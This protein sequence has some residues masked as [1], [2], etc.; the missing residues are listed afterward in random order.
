[1]LEANNDIGKHQARNEPLPPTTMTMTITGQGRGRGEKDENNDVDDGKPNDNE[2]DG[3][4]STHPMLM[5]NC[6]S[7]G[8]QVHQGRMTKGQHHW[9]GLTMTTT[10]QHQQQ[11][12]RGG[13]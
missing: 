9:Q 8:W 10:H 12:Q 4:R 3:Q 7:G 5:S 1:M 11:G 2:D 6:S 13:E